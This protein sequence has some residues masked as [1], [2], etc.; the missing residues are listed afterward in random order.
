MIDG[1]DNNDDVVGGPLQNVTQE[2]VQEFQIATNRFSAESGR[3]ASSVINIVTKSGTDQFRGSASLFLRDDSWQGLPA[4][5]DRDRRRPCR[6]TASSWPAPPAGRSC[7]QKLFWFGAAGVPQP[8]RRR[9]GGRARCGVADDPADLRAGAARRSA[10]VGAR[11]LA[12]ECR[13]WRSGPLRRRARRRHQR[14]HASTA[15]SDRPRSG[16]R[17]RTA[18]SRSSAPGR[19]SGRRRWSTLTTA[20]FSTFDNV[21]HAGGARAAAHVSQHSGRH[22]LP[23]AAGHHA[24]ALPARR[25]DDAGAR[26]AHAARRRRVAE[27]GRALRSRRLPGGPDRVR[28]RTSPTS[29]TTATAGLTTA[30]C[31]SR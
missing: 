15:R 25:H 7:R 9:L 17:A 12:S 22:V 26:R 3:S 20:S 1:A 4:T 24:E 14:Q 10:G 29:I 11:R 6:S 16:R 5:F 27:R 13:R 21:D 8:G 2:S 19:A 31:C 30:I 18:T 28:R 23:R